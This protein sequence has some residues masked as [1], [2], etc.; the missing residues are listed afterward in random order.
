MRPPLTLIDRLQQAGILLLMAGV[1]L[2]IGLALLRPIGR[3]SPARR[4]HGK[5]VLGWMLAGWLGGAGYGVCIIDNQSFYANMADVSM[6]AF[7]MLLG[8][9]VGMIHG[10]IVLA[11][12]PHQAEVRND[13]ST[14]RNGKLGLSGARQQESRGVGDS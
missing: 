10:G 1:I 4:R 3:S 2:W 11:L 8:W 6:A 13:A 14:P 12:S 7:G 5:Y 9:V